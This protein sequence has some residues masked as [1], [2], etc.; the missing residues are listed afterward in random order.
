MSEQSSLFLPS[1]L[2]NDSGWY[3][4]HAGD[5]V[6]RFVRLTVEEPP[7]VPYLTCY[8]RSFAKDILCEWKPS[9]QLSARTKAKLWVGKGLMGGNRTEQPCRYYSRSQKFSCR[10]TMTH[11]DED[12]ALRVTMCV[13]NAAGATT[14]EDKYLMTGS[15]VKPDPPE[16]V[17][18]TPVE[19]AP[20]K[21][22]VTWR[23]PSSWGSKMYQLRFQLRY[24][25]DILQTYLEVEL[26]LETTFYVIHD[27]L[28]NLPHRVQVRAHEEFNYGTW[29]EWSRESTG[30]PWTEPPEA[31]MTSSVPKIPDYDFVTP[32]MPATPES[33]VDP[34]KPN[35]GVA[36]AVDLHSCLIP[37][38]TVILALA[39][40]VGIV[41]R[42]RVKILRERPRKQNAS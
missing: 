15:L 1:V 29:S 28:Q 42:K 13:V 34:G 24:R 25:A 16:N 6:L 39:L 18:V 11:Q 37:A 10:I 33:P 12:I 8:R 9:R 41:L 35:V 3:S 20:R 7:E 40:V 32:D 23:Y 31:E 14:S 21:L 5:S 36:V 30:T 19:K 38:V 22:R 27:A 2:F 17:R 4:C 26:P